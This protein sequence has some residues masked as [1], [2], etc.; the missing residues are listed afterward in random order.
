MQQPASGP[1]SHAPAAAQPPQ[2]S[3]PH[4]SAA[5]AGAAPNHPP[6]AVSWCS[7]CAR[8]AIQGYGTRRRFPWAQPAATPL[9]TTIPS[10]KPL[11]PA[12][13]NLSPAYVSTVMANKTGGHV[14]SKPTRATKDREKSHNSF[15][16]RTPPCRPPGSRCAAGSC[17]LT[18]SATKLVAAIS[19]SLHR[20]RSQLAHRTSR[21][22]LR[23]PAPDTADHA[24]WAFSFRLIGKHAH[25]R[26]KSLPKPRHSSFTFVEQGHRCSS[27]STRQCMGKTRIEHA[28]QVSNGDLQQRIAAQRGAPHLRDGGIDI[29]TAVF[30]PLPFTSP[31]VVSSLH[32]VF[33]REHVSVA[34]CGVVPILAVH[35]CASFAPC[36]SA[37]AAHSFAA[38]RPVRAL[39]AH[40]LA[41]CA[42]MYQMPSRSSTP[43]WC[44]CSGHRRLP[45]VRMSDA[46]HLAVASLKPT[47][48]S[49]GNVPLTWWNQCLETSS[50]SCLLAGTF[51]N[52]MS[53]SVVKMAD[54]K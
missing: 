36:P 42:A 6:I 54:T 41:R 49:R 21:M 31:F 46:V 38:L 33:R 27:A 19:L 11:A 7:G 3:G 29:G 9:L 2:P 50:P 1:A 5:F 40:V 12:E 8:V 10:L 26:E 51:Q 35:R 45:P 53:K 16:H 28:V 24:E 47:R 44:V 25:H 18:A 13:R 43:H 48:T 32:H 17:P 30:L 23:R 39:L 15:P 52:T 34:S 22:C 20:P 4:R 14:D 37:R